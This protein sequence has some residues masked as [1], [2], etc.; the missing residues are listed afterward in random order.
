MNLYER[1]RQWMEYDC[2]KHDLAPD[3]AQYATDKIN[4]MTPNELL[5]AIS[6]ALEKMGIPQP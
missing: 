6:D 3:A 5:Q 4:E 2:R 1:V